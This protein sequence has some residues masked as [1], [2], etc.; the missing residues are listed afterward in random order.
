MCRYADFFSWPMQQ[1]CVTRCQPIIHVP[2]IPLMSDKLV[3]KDG[4]ATGGGQEGC[5]S[6]WLLVH[7]VQ[8]VKLEFLKCQ[9]AA[10]L[11]EKRRKQQGVRIQNIKSQ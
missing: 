2:P 8:V 4:R 1:L 11:L 3:G 10:A 9:D 7:S 6:E 5:V